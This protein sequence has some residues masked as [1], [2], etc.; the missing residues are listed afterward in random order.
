MADAAVTDLEAFLEAGRDRRL[1]L[2]KSFVRIPSVSGQPE[3]A[4]DCQAAAN[5]LAND[6]G[7]AGIEHVAVEETGGHPVVYGD[8][9]HAEG[10]PTVIV[11]G[12]YDVQPADPLELWE[13]PPFEPVLRDGRMIGRGAEDNKACV[14]MHI[15]TVEALLKTRGSLP[16][17]LKFIF[18]GEEESGS[19]NLDGW[20]E[21][22]GTSSQRSWP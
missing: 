19:P 11:Y 21:P 7:A 12:H 22:T 2:W 15:R 10:A 4:I 20:L 6:L 3:H 5:W 18:E 16:V 14:Q 8:W 1:E 13:T 17:N 9:L